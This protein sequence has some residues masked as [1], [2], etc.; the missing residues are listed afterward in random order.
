MISGRIMYF[1]FRNKFGIWYFLFLDK[2]DLAPSPSSTAK[3][4]AG[5]A[6]LAGEHIFAP[7][8]MYLASY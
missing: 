2:D 3:S 7:H 5:S 4:E 6:H 8:L 1:V